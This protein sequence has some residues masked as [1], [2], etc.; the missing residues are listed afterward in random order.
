MKFMKRIIVGL[1]LL[2]LAFVVTGCGQAAADVDIAER[3]DEQKTPVLT[4]GVK[5]DTNL[6]GYYN[7]ESAQIEGF[8]VDIAKALTDE[9]TNGT[10]KAEFVEVT[11]KT[12]IPLLKNGKI[13][14][15]LATMTI[16]EEREKEVDFSDVYFNGGQSLLVH[17]DSEIES[18]EDLTEDHTVLA[19]K[20]SSSTQNMRELAPQVDVLDLENY[21]EG[22]V[23]LQSGQGDALTT[24]NAI[25]LGMIATNPD[26]R[27]AGSNFTDE[28]YGI[29]I[30]KG[31]D[32][33]HKRLEEALDTIQDKG[34]YD[35]VYA[36]WFGEILPADSP[37][38]ASTSTT[39]AANNSTDEEETESGEEE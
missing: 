3:I 33:F 25:L 20:G 10:G 36:K 14:G 4:W 34:V 19:I 12:R 6:F 1:G 30:N 32:E 18:L 2:L 31:Q 13:D 23:A 16:T 21:S 9:M 38:S 17:E 15:I 22:F 7:I 5:A 35:E 26:Y 8:D 37:N 28:P 27:L 24:D 39:G 11:S 29:A